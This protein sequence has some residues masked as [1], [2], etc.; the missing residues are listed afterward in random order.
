MPAP[1]A[2][3]SARISSKARILSSRARST[4]RIL[5]RSGRIAWKRRSRPCLAEPPAESP[6]TRN[7][8]QLL[9]IF[10][11][12][13]GQLAGQGQAFEGALAD[14]QVARFARGLAGARGDQALFDDAAAVG[15]V[16]GQELVQR[17][18]D[19]GLHR[20]ADLGVVEL[21][22]GLALELRVE[23]LDADDRG[24]ALADV[25]AAQVGVGVL[26][27]ARLAGVVVQAAGQRRAEAA[28]VGAAVDGV[29]VVG[30]GVDALGEAVV[31]LQRDLDARRRRRGDRRRT[32]CA[33]ARGSDSGAARTRRCRPRS[34][35]STRARRRAGRSSTRVIVRPLVR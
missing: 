21:V 11:G 23:H 14:D 25:V 3:I 35:T 27:D 12:A 6:S 34:R 22:L 4:F 20:R 15:R 17:R 24:Q 10:L 7:S 30:E 19:H 8:S 5:P 1:S 33:A 16:F 2:V 28:Q 13:V 18:V 29:D 9:G 31:V 32:A 26:E